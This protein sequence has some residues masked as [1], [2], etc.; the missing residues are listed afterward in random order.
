M[1]DE[2][3][4]DYDVGIPL[5]E[6]PPHEPLV[7]EEHDEI[8]AVSDTDPQDEPTDLPD[9]FAPE[10]LAEVGLAD[11]LSEPVGIGED[12]EGLEPPETESTIEAA[13]SAGPE[14][15]GLAENDEPPENLPNELPDAVALSEDPT[16]S[17]FASSD[18]HEESAIEAD[19]P[20]PFALPDD[21]NGENEELSALSEASELEAQVGYQIDDQVADDAI[22]P[23]L[24][25]DRLENL[26]QQISELQ[27]EFEGKLKY[28]AHKDQIIDRLHSELQEYKQDILKKYVLSIVMDVVKV[29]DDIRK[30][31]SYFRSLD[32]SQRDPR[33][34]FRY[35]EAIPS[36]LEDVFY[37]HGVKPF[38]NE[39]GAFDP[40]RQRAIKK[41]PTDDPA[42]DKS[43]AHSIR[44]GYEWESKVIR[45][46]MVAVYVYQV[47]Q[48]SL[49][50]GNIDE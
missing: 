17:E 9:L 33:K 23:D 19:P 2:K 38:S 10:E 1:S 18:M 26:G 5:D 39:E 29:T 16:P 11:D 42:M 49:N 35:L 25:I 44:P 24:L 32:V 6:L 43:V 20:L 37:W 12:D 40:A 8:P 4:T 14:E 28:D 31:L 48:E 45:Q 3:K 22:A 50:T 41:L 7:D 30:W 21:H 15:D 34:L 27:R 13:S 36:D 46:E 47:E